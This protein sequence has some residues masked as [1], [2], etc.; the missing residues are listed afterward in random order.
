VARLTDYDRDT[1]KKRFFAVASGK[2]EQAATTRV[3]RAFTA[4]F[5]AV[6]TEIRRVNGR[7]HKAL[8]LRMQTVESYMCV[9]RTCT[10]LMGEFPSAP[11]YTLHDCL[12][13]DREYIDSF[14]ARLRAEFRAAFGV[15]PKLAQKPF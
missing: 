11:L 13:T 8:A 5:P 2:P 7:N 3:G 12:V 10:E 15:E 9:W 4:E 6:W 14:A 1:V